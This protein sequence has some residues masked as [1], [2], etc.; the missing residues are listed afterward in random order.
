MTIIK[1]VSTALKPKVQG[2]LCLKLPV[3]CYPPAIHGNVIIMLPDEAVFCS[4]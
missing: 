1:L 2:K 3:F 4:H